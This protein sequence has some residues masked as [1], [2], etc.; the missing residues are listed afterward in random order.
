MV[1]DD[2]SLLPSSM[3]FA[4]GFQAGSP[5][6]GVDQVLD[7]EALAAALGDAQSEDSLSRPFVG[8]HSFA[9]VIKSTAQP[10]KGVRPLPCAKTSLIVVCGR[11]VLEN[12]D[13]YQ[14]STLVC[15]FTGFWPS[16]LNLHR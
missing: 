11:E 3:P 12:M 14:C 7:L 10:S 1:V 9:R 5:M 6:A 16:L 15:R 13:F 8:K 2:G 4:R